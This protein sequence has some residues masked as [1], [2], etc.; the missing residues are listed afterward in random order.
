MTHPSMFK[1]FRA[2]LSDFYFVHMLDT[3]QFILY[4]NKEIHTNLM[5]PWVKCALKEECISPPGSKFYGCDFTRRPAFLYSSCHR[6]EMSAFSI[7]TA[8]LF[9]YDQT[10]Y[11]TLS[12]KSYP[13][14]E[15]SS[16][17]DSMSSATLSSKSDGEDILSSFIQSYYESSQITSESSNL[18][19]SL[20][21]NKQKS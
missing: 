1:Y 21:K 14:S 10:K 18:K 5:L 15:I 9:D 16:I 13:N 11:T 19:S 17:Q 3:S 2:K 7:I 6:Y 8:L 20:E 12:D 4:N